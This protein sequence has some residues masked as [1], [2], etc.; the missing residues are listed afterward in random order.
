MIKDGIYYTPENVMEW[1]KRNK[2]VKIYEGP[3]DYKYLENAANFIKKK[4][5]S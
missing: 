2:V 3:A 4:R 1:I 5:Q